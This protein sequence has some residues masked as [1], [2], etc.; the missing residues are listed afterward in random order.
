M[1]F[2]LAYFTPS[3]SGSR[4]GH[5]HSPNKGALGPSQSW[6]TRGSQGNEPVGMT[7]LSP[8]S[9]KQCF[10]KDNFLLSHQPGQTEHPGTAE[11]PKQTL[12]EQQGPPPSVHWLPRPQ[13]GSW[14]EQQRESEDEESVF[15]SLILLLR[16]EMAPPPCPPHL[17]SPTSPAVPGEAL[18]RA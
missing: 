13:A 5:H 14:V 8:T 7:P 4:I 17:A 3:S 18:P 9:G 10:S 6:G 16:E 2:P 12:L 15:F 1:F 11:S